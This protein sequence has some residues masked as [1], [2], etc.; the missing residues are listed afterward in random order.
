MFQYLV[1]ANGLMEDGGA[2]RRWGLG[3]EDVTFVKEQIDAPS[4]DKRKGGV[5][6]YCVQSKVH[7]GCQRGPSFQASAFQGGLPL[8][9]PPSAL[10]LV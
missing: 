3:E 8:P 4:L 5:C 6:Q 9:S 2:L 7:F 10:R 1:E